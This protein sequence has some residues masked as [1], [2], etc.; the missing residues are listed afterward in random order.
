LHSKRDFE[1]VEVVNPSNERADAGKAQILL[2]AWENAG[3]GWAT[4]R[5]ATAIQYTEWL[6]FTMRHLGM[7]D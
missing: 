5:K 4:D 2:H 3:H 7:S 6:A 1:A